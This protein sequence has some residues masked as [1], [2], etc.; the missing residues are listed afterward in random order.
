[1]LWCYQ[2]LLCVCR[3][4]L[5]VA[6]GSYWTCSKRNPSVRWPSWFGG[7]EDT[8]AHQKLLP[9]S[10][11]PVSHA[12][13]AGRAE[14]LGARR[15]DTDGPSPRGLRPGPAALTAVRSAAGRGAR[16]PPRAVRRA[17][18]RG[19]GQRQSRGRAGLPHR[20]LRQQSPRRSRAQPPSVG[21]QLVR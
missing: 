6:L 3:R 15:G 17:G 7:G 4:V 8:Q 2:C 1:M 16:R 12:Q 13:C 11:V 9:S 20:A 5:D 21:L 19:P 14:L 10:A 18:A